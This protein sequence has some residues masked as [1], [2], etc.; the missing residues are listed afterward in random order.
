LHDDYKFE[1][2]EVGDD[3]FQHCYC[4][5]HAAK[6][7]KVKACNSDPSKRRRLL[8]MRDSISPAAG[9]NGFFD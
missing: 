6:S 1:F 4:P 9:L 7:H 5:Q 8:E 3:L 2:R